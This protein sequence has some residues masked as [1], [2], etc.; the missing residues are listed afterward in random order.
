LVG[1]WQGEKKKG[2]VRLIRKLKVTTL[3]IKIKRSGLKVSNSKVFSSV[4]I[5][6]LNLKVEFSMFS[7]KFFS[8]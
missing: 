1:H 6:M 3:Y 5:I 7:N 8:F 4:R 2:K